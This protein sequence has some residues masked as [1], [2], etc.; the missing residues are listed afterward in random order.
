MLGAKMRAVMANLGLATEGTSLL[1]QLRAANALME[2]E[3]S[4]SV[5]EQVER[6]VSVTRHRRHAVPTHWATSSHASSSS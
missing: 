1:K 4:G 3:D 5:L 2:L 6:L